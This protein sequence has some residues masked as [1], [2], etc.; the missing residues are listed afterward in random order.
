MKMLFLVGLFGFLG[1]VLTGCVF[2][3]S[4]S[5]LGWC[6][7]GDLVSMNNVQLT[8][9]ESVAYNGISDS[10]HLQSVLEKVTADYY[11]DQQAFLKLSGSGTAV[12]SGCIVFTVNGDRGQQTS[13]CFGDY[14]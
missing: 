5:S 3:S 14:K 13:M 10:C 12:G 6:N 8:V 1:L 7:A 2:K 4:S 11:L 9:V